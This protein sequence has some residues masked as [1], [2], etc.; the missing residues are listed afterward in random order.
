MNRHWENDEKL[1]QKWS[2]ASHRLQASILID[3]S[4]QHRVGDK[5]KSYTQW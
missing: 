2:F 1:K 3:F 5:E 4:A